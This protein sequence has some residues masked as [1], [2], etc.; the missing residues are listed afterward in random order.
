MPYQKSTVKMS[1]KKKYP[2]KNYKA[3]VPRQIDSK[4]QVHLIKR[5]KQLD[6]IDSNT[7]ADKLGAYSFRLQDLVN[8]TEFTSL[9]DQYRIN[10]IKIKFIPQVQQI[11]SDPT[12]QKNSGIFYHAVD[13]DE[14][15]VPAS[16][17]DL[18]QYENLRVEN[19]LSVFTLYF[20][21]HVANALYAGAFTAYGNTQQWIDSNSPDVQHYGH[22]YCWTQTV[23][24]DL[25]LIPVATFYLAFRKVK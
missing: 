18:L 7:G 19:P 13:Y 3:T 8:Y 1:S 2:K 20:K 9:F 21:P 6:R 14:A 24:A 16:V 12:V 23:A 11:Y 22:K 5:T 15:N 10:A 17:D 4:Y 25:N